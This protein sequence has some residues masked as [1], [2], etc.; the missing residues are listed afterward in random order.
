M[1]EEIKRDVLRAYGLGIGGRGVFL[2]S[3]VD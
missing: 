2:V 3:K 1:M